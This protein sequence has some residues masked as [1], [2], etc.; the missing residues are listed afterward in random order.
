MDGV[1]SD[2]GRVTSD[3][4]KQEVRKFSGAVWCRLSRKWSQ[5]SPPAHRQNRHLSVPSVPS[6]CLRAFSDFGSVPRRGL[7]TDEKVGLDQCLP[8][9][10]RW[11]GWVFHPC[12]R[13]SDIDSVICQGRNS[14]T[15]K[16]QAQVQRGTEA[17]PRET[18]PRR[19]QDAANLSKP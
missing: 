1:S 4:G 6:Q 19:S 15:P 2:G 8:S 18:G 10:G 5:K 14:V 3:G 9:L 12:V 11:D 13:C 16:S 17:Q 7:G